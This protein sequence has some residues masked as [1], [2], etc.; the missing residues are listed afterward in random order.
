MWLS[1]ILKV[2]VPNYVSDP[3]MTP[4]F[5]PKVIPDERV[6]QQEHK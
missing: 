6:L 4:M 3:N 1:H 5:S 2:E